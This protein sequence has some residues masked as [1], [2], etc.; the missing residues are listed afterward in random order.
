MGIDAATGIYLFDGGEPD[1]P[2]V[3]TLNLLSTSVR[4]TVLA[5]R[6]EM[7]ALDLNARQSMR[8]FQLTR[9]GIGDNPSRYFLAR[10]LE[11]TAAASPNPFPYSY[12]TSGVDNG[13][14]LFPAGT[15]GF[16]LFGTYSANTSGR[17]T[18]SMWVGLSTGDAASGGTLLRESS[19][20]GIGSFTA[21]MVVNR[22]KF[23]TATRVWF[24]TEKITGGTAN[25]TAEL[26]VTRYEGM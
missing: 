12:S 23:S 3:D 17:S 11:D 14:F 21:S 24:R 10:S 5:L 9:N 4:D 19:W 1:F 15:Y 18:M 2:M 20:G 7:S 26:I 8:K 16:D 13:G 22:I 25:A 6:G